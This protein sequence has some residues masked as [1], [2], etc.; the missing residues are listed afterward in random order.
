MISKL[1]KS[2]FLRGVAVVIVGTAT[3]QLISLLFSPLLTRVYSP[4]AFGLLGAF[5]A[6]LSVLIPFCTM[7]LP[8]AIVL[9]KEESKA[10]KLVVLTLFTSV[11]I[12]SLI[13][14]LYYLYSKEIGDILNLEG[15][16][17]L[18]Y[19]I[20][21]AMICSTFYLVMNYRVLRHELYK[22]KA[23]ASVI[24]SIW[25]NISKLAIGFVYPISITLVALTAISNGVFAIILLILKNKK[26][27]DKKHVDIN[28]DLRGLADIGKEYK[29]F[30]IYRTPQSM[31]N[32]ISQNIPTI[33][34]ATFFGAASVGYYTLSRMV[35]TAPV[36]LIGQSVSSVFLP[37]F[38][39]K[40]NSNENYNKMLIMSVL[41][42]FLLAIIP[43]SILFFQGENIFNFVFGK[44]WS[45]AGI[46]AEWLAVWMFF[47]FI[48][49][50]C[51]SA[52]S[53]LNL[54]FGF[55]IYEILSVSLRSIGI[56]LGLYYF[57]SDITAIALFSILG[58][59]LNLSLILWVIY[60]SIR[61]NS[62]AVF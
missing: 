25:F 15:S 43:F 11:V 61:S 41:S 37:K 53:V 19:F 14:F 33:L 57:N 47:G 55:L 26:F 8:I 50:P 30:A 45:T 17:G 38:N 12:S 51:V 28:I 1:K 24:H 49:T 13:A 27:P 21:V 22:I 3:A 56:I 32:A 31:I 58:G 6:I 54:Q 7:S 42:L 2:K 23:Q 60:N 48:N 10:N 16:E 59:A 36:T 4:T 20:P 52:I 62:K 9:P 5:T 29:R 44:E 46:Y 40:Y 39:A 34:L 35:L 18:Y